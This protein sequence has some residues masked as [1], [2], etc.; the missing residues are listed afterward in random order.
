MI[1]RFWISLLKKF[2]ILSIPTSV[3]VISIFTLFSKGIETALQ[4]IGITGVILVICAC[5]IL[6]VIFEINNTI[7]GTENLVNSCKNS[8]DI[9]IYKDKSLYIDEQIKCFKKAHERIYVLMDSLNPETKDSK[10]VDFDIALKNAK[11]SQSKVDVKLLTP[12]TDEKKRV[13]GAYD[14]FKRELDIK[15]LDILSNKDLRF[16]LIDED[17][18]I[19]SC[20]ETDSGDFSRDFVKINSETLNKLLRTYFDELWRSEDSL[21]F[22]E[23]LKERLKSLGVLRGHISIKKASKILDIPEDFLSGFV[24]KLNNLG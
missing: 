9:T 18:V 20:S 12:N 1:R 3:A 22:E 5:F 23:Y 13:R 10:L 24:K 21:N 16:S 19:I 17:I 8:N 15:F 14:I 2:L 11:N 6:T 4:K 7:R